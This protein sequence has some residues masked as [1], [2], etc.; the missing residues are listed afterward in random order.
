MTTLAP[1]PAT[2]QPVVA[3]FEP[4]SK[5]LAALNGLIEEQKDLVLEASVSKPR[6]R[7]E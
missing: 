6:L 1:I 4:T 7:E 5:H 3:K 2:A